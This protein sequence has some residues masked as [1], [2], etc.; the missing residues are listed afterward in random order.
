MLQNHRRNSVQ[1]AELRACR[2][3]GTEPGGKPAAHL[4]GG[5]HRVGH[6]Q[7]LLRRSARAQK[8]VAQ[9]GDQH[10]GL[11]AARHCQQQHGAPVGCD[12]RALLRIERLHILI[13]ERC[14]VHTIPPFSL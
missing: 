10:G 1:R 12:R 11:A 8:Q 2:Q 4:V 6:R 9:P 13:L 14:L 5:G 7:G 3:L